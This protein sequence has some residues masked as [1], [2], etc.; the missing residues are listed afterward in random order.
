MKTTSLFTITIFLLN[1]SVSNGQNTWF[2]EFKNGDKIEAKVKAFESIDKK[3]KYKNLETGKKGK[4]NSNELESI[5]LINPENT[6]VFK[7]MKARAEAGFGKIKQTENFAWVAKIDS[8]EKM[9]GYLYFGSDFGF[10]TNGLG[11]TSTNSFASM[12]QAIKLVS[13]DHVFLMG[14]MEISGKGGKKGARNIMNKA[15]K[16]YTKSYCPV[17]SEKLNKTSYEVTELKKILADYTTQC[18]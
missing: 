8:T 12:G 10:S 17:F 6:L 5:T 9:V 2:I 11:T 16:R 1:M 15:L 3:I 4:V 14:I 18:N 13:E 7:R